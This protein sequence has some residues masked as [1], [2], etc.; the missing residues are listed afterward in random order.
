MKS[1]NVNSFV[2]CLFRHGYTFEQIAGRLGVSTR[3]VQER[4]RRH[5]NRVNRGV[6]TV[7][8]NLLNAQFQIRMLQG[9]EKPV[10]GNK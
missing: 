6:Q 8:L 3:R 9:M 7:R 10:E 2:D 1:E 4:Y 5:Q